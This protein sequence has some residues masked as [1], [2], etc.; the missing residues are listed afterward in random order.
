MAPDL[1]QR[2]LHEHLAWWGLRHLTSDRNYFAWQ[3]QQFSPDDLTQL[4]Y[5]IEQKRTGG[6]ENEIAF[7]DRTAQT[8]IYPVLYSQ[9]YEYY[10]EIGRRVVAEIGKAEEILD[11]GCGPGILTTFYARQFPEKMFVGVDRS[12]VSIALAQRKA[13]ELGLRNIRFCHIDVE[14]ESLSGSYELVLATHALLQ[15]EQ[16]P[17][18]PSHSWRTF[19]RAHSPEQQLS[20]EQR[21]GLAVR[22]DELCHVLKKHGR[23]IAFEKTRQLARRVPFQRALA[24]RGFQPIKLPEPIR[25]CS[26]EEVVDDGPFYV[27]QKGSDSPFSWDESLEPDDGQAFIPE[28]VSIVSSDSD[29]PL[30]DNHW[31]SAQRAWEQLH[32]R[33]VI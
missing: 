27:L 9:R 11:F 23:M 13:D 1:R 2:S 5:L 29:A 33:L 26:I 16:D 18:I 3:R 7:Y 21:T 25:Y 20:F 6:R 14:M 24:Q 31:P 10:E 30:Y 17:G 19:D 8:G 22:L 4:H 28:T 32:N 15:A 12:L